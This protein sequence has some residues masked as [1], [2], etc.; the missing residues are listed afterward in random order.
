MISVDISAKI[1]AEISTEMQNTHVE[2]EKEALLQKWDLTSHH[3]KT[4]KELVN[5]LIV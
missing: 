1:S 3:T 4:A 5:W 2:I